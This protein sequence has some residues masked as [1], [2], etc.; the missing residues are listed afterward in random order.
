VKNLAG[1]KT[2]EA[3]RIV[4]AELESAGIDQEIFD[5]GTREV[6]TTISGRIGDIVLTRAWYYWVAKGD[7]PVD[8]AIKIH[9][10]MGDVVRAGGDCACRPPPKHWTEYRDTGHGFVTS[11]HID[12]QDGLDFF[13]GIIREEVDP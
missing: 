12:S 13:A 9:K 10:G 5:P 2:V 1:I 8:V 7:V 11:Y 3:N 6:Q 4:A